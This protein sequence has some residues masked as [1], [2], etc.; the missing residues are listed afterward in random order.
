MCLLDC[1]GEFLWG[2]PNQDLLTEITW[3]NQSILF[4]RLR[5]SS[6]TMCYDPSDLRSLTLIR[7]I[8]KER[9]LCLFSSWLALMFSSKVVETPA[10][11]FFSVKIMI[12]GG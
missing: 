3:I 10:Q 11:T 5:N 2:D 8:T 7:I 4:Q 6:V 12:P 1:L 9:M